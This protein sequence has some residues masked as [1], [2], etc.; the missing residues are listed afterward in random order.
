MEYRRF[1][2]LDRAGHPRVLNFRRIIDFELLAI[3]LACHR[4]YN[5]IAVYRSGKRRV[6]D[7]AAHGSGQILPI[8]PEFHTGLSRPGRGFHRESPRT[9]NIRGESGRRRK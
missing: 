7:P 9:G 2:E 5:L 1:A 3:P 4:K 8:L 6:P